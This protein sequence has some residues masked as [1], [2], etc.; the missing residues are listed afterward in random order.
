MKIAVLSDIHGNAAALEACLNYAR[1]NSVSEFVF[2]GDYVGELAFPQKTMEMLYQLMEGYPCHFVKGNKEDYWL[3]YRRDGECGWK[4]CDSTTG[5]LFY[6]YY[7]LTDRDLKF[8]ESL[9][10][11]SE[12]RKD[13]LPSITICH[14]SPY[15][16]NEKMLPG[17]GKTQN[18]IEQDPNDFILCG[19]THVQGEIVHQCKV[20][21]NPGSVGVSLHGNGKAQ[22]MILT[23][24]DGMWEHEFVSLDYDV[25]KVIRDLKQSGL[26]EM[27]PSW[28]KVSAHLLRTGE[29]SH[30]TVLAKAMAFC[31]EETGACVWPEIP[32]EYW[33]LAVRNLLEDEKEPQ[34]AVGNQ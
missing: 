19:H 32:E 1:K 22:F 25:E 3:N 6:T 18:V 34:C 30:G 14:G 20:V 11:K 27:A 23:D 31:K 7:N 4:E 29:V 8:F 28:C 24:K 12:L 33:G 13:G 17:N 10:I 21:W 26:W 5:S 16:A 9:N 15:H 2:L